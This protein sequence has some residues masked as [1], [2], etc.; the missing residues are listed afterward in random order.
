MM[1]RSLQ[2]PSPTHPFSHVTFKPVLESRPKSAVTIASFTNLCMGYECRILTVEVQDFQWTV[3][4]KQEFGLS[5]ILLVLL[6]NVA[7]P[8]NARHVAEGLK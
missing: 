4:L 3:K 7:A 1:W 8:T 6:L 5:L 2:L